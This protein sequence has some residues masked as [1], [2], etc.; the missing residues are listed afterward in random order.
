MKTD[1]VYHSF[2][3][4]CNVPTKAERKPPVALLFKKAWSIAIKGL[5]WEDQNTTF[6]PDQS[7]VTKGETK[8][9]SKRSSNLQAISI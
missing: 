8:K 9:L 6:F 5:D 2:L 3:H 4:Q 1:L 7:R